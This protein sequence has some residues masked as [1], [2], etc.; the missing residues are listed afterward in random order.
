VNPDRDCDNKNSELKN[1]TRGAGHINLSWSSSAMA[2]GVGLF[3]VG[4]Q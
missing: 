2:A 3:I 1:W 4:D